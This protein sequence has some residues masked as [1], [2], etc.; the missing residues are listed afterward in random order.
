MKRW[1]MLLTVMILAFT[2]CGDEGSDIDATPASDTG[3]AY[4]T[5]EIALLP[6]EELVEEDTLLTTDLQT[7]QQGEPALY[8]ISGGTGDDGEYFVALDEYSLNSDGVWQ[9]R[10]FCEKSLL[11]Y[12]DDKRGRTREFERI[13]RGDDGNLYI[14]MKTGELEMGY[15]KGK[16]D[17]EYSV[18]L[19]DEENDGIKEIKLQTS[20]TN[21]AGEEVD[22]AKEYDVMDFHV[23]EDGTIFLVFSCASA[24]WFD[25]ESGI[26]MNF[27]DTIADSAFSK[28][29]AYGESEILYYSTSNKMFRVL[30]AETLTVSG[31]FMKGVSEEDRDYEWFFDVDTSEWQMY[32]FNKSGLYQMSDLGRKASALRISR[33]GNFDNL[34]DA[35]IY[36][37]MVGAKQQVYVLLRVP[38]ENDDSYESSWDYGVMTYNVQQ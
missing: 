29:V 9:T 10:K 25:G 18:L 28:N 2:G 11:D 23:R 34:A 38:A 16:G 22:Y 30:D 14:L 24:M 35:D 5:E 12:Y 21:E 33:L 3:N 27:C 6:D 7:N 26:Q 19:I 1:W 37:V 31:E 4:V 36:D 32:A 8:N 15:E 13:V 17:R 20:V